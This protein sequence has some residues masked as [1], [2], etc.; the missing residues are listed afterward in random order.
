MRPPGYPTFLALLYLLFRRDGV[1]IVLAQVLLDMGTCYLIAWLAWRLAPAPYRRR[2][3]LA[4]LWLAVTC[5]FVAN[6]AAVP[7]TE[8]LEWL[9]TAAGMIPLVTAFLSIERAE[10]ES[11]RITERTHWF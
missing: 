7:L 1:V 8:V 6:C 3:S 4:A 10:T 11:G 2:I 9:V 5:P